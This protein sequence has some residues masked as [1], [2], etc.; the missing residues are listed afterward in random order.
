MY[1]FYGNYSYQ[2]DAKNR[3]RMPAKFRNEMGDEYLIT[4]GTSGCL[5]VLHQK[6]MEEINA[7]IASVPITDVDGGKALRQ[8]TAS[9]IRV[10]CDE[11][12]RFVLPPALKDFAK[13]DK[14]VCIVGAGNKVEIWSQEIWDKEFGNTDNFDKV[15][16]DLAK[17]GI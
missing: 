5:F 3:M 14:N 1:C 8:F 15:F 16:N 2:L 7:K 11:Q 12:G 10:E 6:A 17:Y 9:A 4:P 13:I